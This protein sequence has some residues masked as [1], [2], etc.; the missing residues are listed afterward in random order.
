MLRSRDASLLRILHPLCYQNAT[1]FGILIALF[2]PANPSAI[3]SLLSNLH[4]LLPTEFRY[5]YLY[6]AFLYQVQP[7]SEHMHL[8]CNIRQ[9]KTLSQSTNK[10]AH[11]TSKLATN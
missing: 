6:L 11:Y 4:Q 10:L 7:T 2:L 5:R 3:N 1:L 9:L 8:T